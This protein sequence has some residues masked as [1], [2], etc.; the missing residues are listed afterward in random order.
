MLCGDF[1]TVPDLGYDSSGNWPSGPFQLL[2]QGILT[3]DHPQHP[4]TFYSKVEC[5]PGRHG[6]DTTENPRLGGCEIVCSKPLTPPRKLSNNTP[7]RPLTP[8]LCL[9]APPPIHSDIPF[10][11]THTLISSDLPPP[12][13][14]NI[15]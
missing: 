3:T 14:P 11:L 1:N 9:P 7:L 13:S 6:H 4:D 10:P 2:E 15:H 12:L 5:T 8:P